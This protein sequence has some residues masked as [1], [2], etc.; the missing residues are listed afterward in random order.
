MAVDHLTNLFTDTPLS[1]ASPLPHSACGVATE[2]LHPSAKLFQNL[3]Q[4]D[5]SAILIV[6]KLTVC[7]LSS[8]SIP[9]TTPDEPQQ[10]HGGGR[11]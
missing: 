1:G 8:A 11:P 2:S 4:F 5:P 3:T 10:Q 7:E 9:R 6:S